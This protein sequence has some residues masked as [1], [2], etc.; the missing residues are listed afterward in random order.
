MKKITLLL[1][2]ILIILCSFTAGLIVEYEIMKDYKCQAYNV[3]NKCQEYNA[4]KYDGR[5]AMYD[6]DEIVGLKN[7]NVNGLYYIG[8]EFYVVWMQNR[9]LDAI[10]ETDRHEYCHWLVDLQHEHFCEE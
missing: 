9:T 4:S 1:S 6:Y 5:C 2:L 10:E 8:E 7:S 3:S